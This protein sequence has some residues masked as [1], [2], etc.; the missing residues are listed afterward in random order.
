M[1][2]AG[3]EGQA[4]A[5][6]EADEIGHAVLGP[7]FWVGLVLGGAMMVYA[8][9]GAADT[10]GPTFNRWVLWLVSADLLH[11]LIVAPIVVL[12]AAG[13]TRLIRNQRVRV[14]LQVGLIASAAVMAVAWI[15]LRGW[16]G[17]ANPTV[18]PINYATATLTAL[19][20]VWAAVVVVS[21]AR[22][23]QAARSTPAAAGRRTED[24]AT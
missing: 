15:P 13:L 21:A 11:D 24:V 16:G 4:P 14:T 8:V 22:A 6:S 1:S 7:M 3:D 20:I 10:I 5:G 19:A 18:R 2:G 17:S 9:L 12:V 23:V